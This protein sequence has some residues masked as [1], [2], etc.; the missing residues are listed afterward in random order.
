M[1]KKAQKLNKTNLKKLNNI[2]HLKSFHTKIKSVN[3]E[4]DD[5]NIFIKDFEYFISTE[6]K[7]PANDLSSEDKIFEGII[8]RLDSL[9]DYKNITVKIYLESQKNPKYILIMNKYIKKYS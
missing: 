9:S 2:A 6:L 1:K 5:F 4:Y 8:S 7:P 3:S